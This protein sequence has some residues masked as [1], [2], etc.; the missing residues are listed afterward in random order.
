MP[1]YDHRNSPSYVAA[2]VRAET[3]KE[4]N[5]LANW[6]CQALAALESLEIRPKDPEMLDW[7]ETHKAWDAARKESTKNEE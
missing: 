3:E 1:C 2:E 5:Q 6:L 7:W 4:R